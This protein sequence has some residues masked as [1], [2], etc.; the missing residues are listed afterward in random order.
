[1]AGSDHFL[2]PEKWPLKKIKRGKASEFL[3]VSVLK[4]SK[5]RAVNSAAQGNK[6]GSLFLGAARGQDGRLMSMLVLTGS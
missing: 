6:P 2:D 5:P 1:L 3:C 4:N